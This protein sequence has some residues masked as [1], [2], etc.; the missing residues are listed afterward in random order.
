MDRPAVSNN[1][2]EAYR[3]GTVQQAR[4]VGLNGGA[5]R[6]KKQTKK[7]QTKKR[8]T[9]KRQ[10]KKRKRKRNINLKKYFKL[11]K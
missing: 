10:T 2:G 1:G 3:V 6:K 5:F 8:Q 7:R 9:K 11:L 4:V